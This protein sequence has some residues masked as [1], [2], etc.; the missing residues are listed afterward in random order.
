MDITF[1]GTPHST[2]YSTQFPDASRPSS[3]QH[4]AGDVLSFCTELPLV[5]CGNSEVG[6][7]ALLADFPVIPGTML[8]CP[9]WEGLST[10]RAPW[11]YS[12]LTARWS[13]T[14]MGWT[15]P[16]TSV[17]STTSTAWWT[18]CGPMTMRC[19]PVRSVGAL[20][21]ATWPPAHHRPSS[22]AMDTPIPLTHKRA[23]GRGENLTMKKTGQALTAA[24]VG[25]YWGCLAL[26][27]SKTPNVGSDLM[28]PPPPQLTW[29]VA[30]GRACPWVIF[31][32]SPP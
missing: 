18:L 20:L 24:G 13:D 16:R 8:T 19:G 21:P 6:W 31:Q 7:G 3:G 14:C 26:C 32:L 10:A 29:G 12:T 30:A 22:P 4:Q 15:G 5:S 1:G 2:H 25:K 17:P 9:S 11:E 23:S 28:G 27:P